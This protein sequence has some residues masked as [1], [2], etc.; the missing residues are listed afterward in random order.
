MASNRRPSSSICSVL[1][2]ASGLST[3]VVLMAGPLSQLDDDAPFRRIDAGANHLALRAGHFPVS[4]VANLALAELADARVADALAAAEGQVEALLLAGDEDRLAA[5]ALD[6]LLRG[7]E[8][9]RAALALLPEAELGLEALQVQAGASAR[10]GP[11]LPHPGR[12]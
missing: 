9:D 12:P 4:Q 7:G 2:R 1:S 3:S 8:D 5:V 11:V 6:L 10:G